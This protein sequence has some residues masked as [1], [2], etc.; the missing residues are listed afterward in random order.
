MSQLRYTLLN[1]KAKRTN[2][3]YRSAILQWNLFAGIQEY[4]KLAGVDLKFITVK[5]GIETALSQFSNFLL[6]DGKNASSQKDY[7]T[8]TK[9]QYLSGVK[10]VLKNKFPAAFEKEN[11]HWCKDLYVG[12]EMR[13]KAKAIALGFSVCK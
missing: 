7:A 2:D 9:A 4:P 12:L 1:T 11:V 5:P 6:Q 10:M 3:G 13:S 8:G